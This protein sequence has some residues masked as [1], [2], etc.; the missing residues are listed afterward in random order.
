MFDFT[1][2]SD[3]FRK[4]IRESQ[5]SVW[6]LEQMWKLSSILSKNVF[7]SEKLSISCDN[8]VYSKIEKSSISK[9]V[10]SLWAWT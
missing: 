2:L 10:F 1:K 8:T 6:Q 9:V 3:P 5:I 4:P 7:T